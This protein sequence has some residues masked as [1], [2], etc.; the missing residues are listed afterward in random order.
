MENK[1]KDKRRMD[2]SQNMFQIIYKAKE[3]VLYGT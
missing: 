2:I 1:N 3:S